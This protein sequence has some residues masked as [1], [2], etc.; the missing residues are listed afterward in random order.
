LSATSAV[1]ALVQASSLS[2]PGPPLTPIAPIT[3]L[4]ALIGKRGP[5]CDEIPRIEGAPPKRPLFF[6]A[7]RESEE[8]R[9]GDFASAKI[10]ADALAELG[11]PCGKIEHVVDQLEHEPEIAAEIRV[12]RD[13]WFE[14][15]SLQR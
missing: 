13:R 10:V 2:A 1:P 3:W 11:L 14:S 6:I 7:A 8:D 9:Q 5:G 15:G 4:P 12:P